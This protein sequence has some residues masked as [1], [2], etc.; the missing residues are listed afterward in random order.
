MSQTFD[1]PMLRGAATPW[2]KQR[3]PWLLMAGPAIVVCASVYT[4][5]LAFSAPDPVVVGDYYKKGKAIN[6]DL[7]R[8]R[9]ASA[10][11][12]SLELGYDASRGVLTGR[13]ARQHALSS[14]GAGGAGGAGD[15]GPAPSG[16]I[17][18]SNGGNGGSGVKPEQ[19]SVQLSHATLPD[20]DIRLLVQPAADGTFALNLPMLERS[21]WVVL[22]EGEKR[23][24]RLA[25]AWV[26]PKE[27]SVMLVAD[28]PQAAA[29]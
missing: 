9:V 6:Q 1:N 27:R 13:I 5:Y 23:D 12:L 15:N 26:W 7:R 8:D 21:R 2:Y 18:S 16:S 24:W 11:G 4:P 14:G 19:L 3:W 28:V 25:G 22:V 17:N 10:M 20:K 29:Q